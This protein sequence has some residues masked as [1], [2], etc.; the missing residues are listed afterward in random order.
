MKD[1]ML[2][3]SSIPFLSVTRDAHNPAMTDHHGHLLYE[4][5]CEIRSDM[6]AY[7]RAVLQ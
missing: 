1:Q 5:L 6:V 2:S 4:K 3:L 7:L